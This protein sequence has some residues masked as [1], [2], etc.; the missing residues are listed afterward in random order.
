MILRAHHIITHGLE[1]IARG[2][3]HVPHFVPA[4]RGTHALNI[5]T[6]T[7]IFKHIS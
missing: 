6:S 2:I 1:T 4:A 7:N 3:E 5:F